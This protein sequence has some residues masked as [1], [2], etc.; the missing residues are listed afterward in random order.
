MTDNPPAQPLLVSAEL[1]EGQCREVRL[2]PSQRESPS[3]IIL[4][5]QG[6]LYAYMNVCPHL[7]VPLN[8]RPDGFWTLDRSALMCAMHGAL[9]QPT[10]GLCTSGPCV[11]RSLKSRTV[12][13][14]DR[15][16]WLA[17]GKR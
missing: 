10:T 14:D 5:H 15:T 3:L 1:T 7:R 16:I 4:R 17:P 12:F 6:Q 11:G 13:E 9:F 8:W 2:D